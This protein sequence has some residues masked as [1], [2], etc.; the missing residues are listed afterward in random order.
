MY[1]SI[2]PIYYLFEC[3]SKFWK[4]LIHLSN[5]P[6]ANLPVSHQSFKNNLSKSFTQTYFLYSFFYLFIRGY[7]SYLSSS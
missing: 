2:S 4:S 3:C 6:I 5:F 1:S 7:I